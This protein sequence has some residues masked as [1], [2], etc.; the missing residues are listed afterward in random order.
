M[1]DVKE[2]GFF[3]DENFQGTHFVLQKSIIPRSKNLGVQEI[4]TESCGTKCLDNS[5]LPKLSSERCKGR[6]LCNRDRK[7]QNSWQYNG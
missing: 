1:K 3:I 7:M 5:D 2:L 6:I 4:C